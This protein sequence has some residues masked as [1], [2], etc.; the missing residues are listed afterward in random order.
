[1]LAISLQSGSNGN[2]IYVETCGLKLL[3]DAGISGVQAEQRLAGFGKEIRRV[4][5]LIISHDHSDHM[6][7]AGVY[8]RK[9]GIPVYLTPPTMKAGK[10]IFSGRER[11]VHFKSG[12]RIDF[13]S[14][15]VRTVPTPHDG[16]DGCAFVISARGKRLGI[17]TDL[18]HI[19]EGLGRCLSTLDAVFLESNYDPQMLN[20]GPYPCFLKKRISGPGGHISNME[21]ATLLSEFGKALKWACLAHLS[22]NN[23]T[24]ELAMKTHKK[25]NPALT[26][27]AA[28]RYGA[29]GALKV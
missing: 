24:P 25:V 3:F 23:N 26:L 27:A 2:S 6:E 14:V 7:Y 4:D 15:E 29:T 20:D 21:S 10:H 19:F 28:S 18:G 12:E 9:F 1:M 8:A 17:F 11:L 22:G 16:A 5:A 13:G